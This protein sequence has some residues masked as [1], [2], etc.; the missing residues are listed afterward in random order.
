MNYGLIP[1][2]AIDFPLLQSDHG[3]MCYFFI[4]ILL[5]HFLCSLTFNSL[6]LSHIAY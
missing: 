4:I 6:V 3:L 2:K 1:T 5:S